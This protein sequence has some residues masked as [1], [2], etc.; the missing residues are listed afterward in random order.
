MP[1]D[2]H[3]RV[4]R[5]EQLDGPFDLYTDRDFGAHTRC[6]EPT[7]EL[8]DASLEFGVRYAPVAEHESGSGLRRARIGQVRHV[9][10]LL[11]P[12]RLIHHCSSPAV[13][14]RRCLACGLDCA[15]RDHVKIAAVSAS[16][17][18]G[19]ALIGSPG[20]FDE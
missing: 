20:D 10:P 17:M 8:G 9:R 16:V 19:A 2:R 18:S 7:T 13:T 4:N 6:R 11:I 15:P 12:V 14:V 1:A 5:Y 3:D